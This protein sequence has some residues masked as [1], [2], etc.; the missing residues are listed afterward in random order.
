MRDFQVRRNQDNSFALYDSQDRFIDGIVVQ[1]T[2]QEPVKVVATARMETGE[3]FYVALPV[4]REILRHDP[5]TV[6]ER[7]KLAALTWER[8]HSTE[9]KDN[10]AIEPA[11]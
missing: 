8:G 10:R 4:T 6:E 5:Q 1:D 3:K 9:S 2:G 11:L 7:L